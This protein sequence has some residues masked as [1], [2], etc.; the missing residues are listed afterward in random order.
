MYTTFVS[1]IDDFIYKPLFQQQL[2]CNR[3]ST[4]TSTCQAHLQKLISECSEHYYKHLDVDNRFQ[5]LEDHVVTGALINLLGFEAEDEQV[6]GGDEAMTPGDGDSIM[7]SPRFCVL[8]TQMILKIQVDVPVIFWGKEGSGKSALVLCLQSLYL[9]C[10]RQCTII[11]H[12]PILQEE[13]ELTNLLQSDS[14][15]DI[16]VIVIKV[17][18]QEDVHKV[19]KMVTNKTING[20]LCPSNVKFVVEFADE[21][22]KASFDPRYLITVTVDQVIVKGLLENLGLPSEIHELL[23]PLL[24]NVSY[25][26]VINFVKVYSWIDQVFFAK[27][28]HLLMSTSSLTSSASSL[29]SACVLVLAT[30]TVFGTVSDELIGD[31]AKHYDIESQHDI[32]LCFT[33]DYVAKVLFKRSNRY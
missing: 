8:M 27:H 31:I 26:A 18:R 6:S 33:L 1:T 15:C 7:M 22:L 3:T 9:K 16:V 17:S 11:S 10:K 23:L 30:E 2:E 20:Q 21:S 19:L 24:S 12:D 32:L 14:Q 25:R 4:P 5:K 13:S 28:H 29:K